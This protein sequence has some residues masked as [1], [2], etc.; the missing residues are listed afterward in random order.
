MTYKTQVEVEK[1]LTSVYIGSS[2][3]HILDFIH[4]LRKDDI[5]AL[6]KEVEGMKRQVITRQ[7]EKGLMAAI[8]QTDRAINVGYNDAI[9]DFLTLLDGLGKD[10]V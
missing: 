8:G 6:K 4:Q 2:R 9:K 1:E 10:P 7:D 3:H 5:E